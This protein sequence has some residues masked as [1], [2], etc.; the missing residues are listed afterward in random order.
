V[1]AVSLNTVGLDDAAAHR[2]IADAAAA[3]GLLAFDPF[4][5]GGDGL[6]DAVL[7]VLP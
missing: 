1:A 7:A 4:R 5:F 3:A 2:A 6:A